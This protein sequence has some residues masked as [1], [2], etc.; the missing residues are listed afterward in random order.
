MPADLTAYGQLGPRNLPYEIDGF[1]CVLPLRHD[2]EGSLLPARVN[3]HHYIINCNDI[4]S[5]VFDVDGLLV[6]TEPAILA[7]IF[8]ASE[9]L[10]KADRKAELKE[11]CEEIKVKCFGRSDEDMSARLFDLLKSYSLWRDEIANLSKDEFNRLF[12]K[13]RKEIFLELITSG[14]VQPMPGAIEFIMRAY[15]K[16]G[17]LAIN[18]GSPEELSKPMLEHVFKDLPV[19]INTVFPCRLRTYV[20]DLAAGRGKPHPDG[21]LRA[22]RL[23]KIP[24]ERLLFVA[25]RGNDAISGISAGYAGGIVV[26]E[27]AN[28]LAFTSEENPKHSTALHLKAQVP[29]RFEAIKDRLIFIGSLGWCDLK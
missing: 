2:I 17:P 5:I 22:S 24:P 9:N 4:K 28:F 29:E 7:A 1:S 19:D 20:S 21:Y 16:F 27:D 11:R 8:L 18:T 14:N 3:S 6:N 12:I 10:I 15:K 13:E 25:D 23:L 26:A